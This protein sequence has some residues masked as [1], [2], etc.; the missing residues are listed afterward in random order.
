MQMEKMYLSLLFMHD[1]YLIL[2]GQSYKPLSVAID[3]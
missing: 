2:V 1:S 3:N